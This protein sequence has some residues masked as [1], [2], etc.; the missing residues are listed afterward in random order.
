L[1]DQHPG[2]VWWVDLTTVDSPDEVGLA[3]AA[4]V[5]AERDP[6][7]SVEVAL[8]TRLR[9]SGAT[10][11]IVD[12]MEHVL[13]AAGTLDALLDRLPD[14]RSLVSSRLALRVDRERVIALD[15]LD[16]RSGLELIARSVGRRGGRPAPSDADGDALR[17]IVG[18]LDGLPLALE[19]AAG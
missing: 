17:E 5:G 7:G 15:G 12:N 14:L 18:L 16:E 2:G 6:E 1:L 3:I 8:T 9:N 13:A 19:L 11:V 10:L 4:V